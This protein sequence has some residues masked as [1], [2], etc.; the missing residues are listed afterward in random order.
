M[1]L[2][3]KIIDEKLNARSTDELMA[4]IRAAKESVE[5]GSTL[6]FCRALTVLENRLSPEEYTKFEDSL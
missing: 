5:E 6:I 1:K 4:D 3:V 2:V